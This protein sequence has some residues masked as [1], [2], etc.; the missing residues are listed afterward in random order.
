MADKLAAD[1][2]IDALSVRQPWAW[3]IIHA[4][5]P[6]E[7]RSRFAIDK[8]GMRA[9]VGKRISIHAGKGMTRYEYEGAALFMHR[10]GIAVPPAAELQRGG[11]IG[12]VECVGIAR[13]ATEALN[14]PWFV[15]PWGLLL[16]RPV[17]VPFVGAQGALGIFRWKP[18]GAEPEAS[19]QWMLPRSPRFVAPPP[20]TAKLL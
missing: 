4:G 13:N 16:A 14:S 6:V 11:I 20:V 1:L 5:K 9:V 19:A 15:G 2:P 3:A 10:L 7:N 12:T 18:N 8:G 17:P